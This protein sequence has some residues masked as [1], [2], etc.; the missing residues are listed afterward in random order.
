[1]GPRLKL[2]PYVHAFI[3]RHGRPRFYFRRRGFQQV[4]LHGLPWSAEFMAAY[5]A[6]LS[7]APQMPIGAKRAGP[8][9]VNEAIARYL[10]ST[11]FT[12]VLAP[13]TQALRRTYLERFRNDHGEK[14]LA[15]MEARH[16]AQLLGTLRPH[17]QRNMLKALRGLMAF[18][19]TEG[20]IPVDP[21]ASYKPTR[22][23]DTGGFAPWTDG[24]I[25]KFEATHPVGSRARLALALL[26]F[27]G[28]RR[29]DVVRIGRQHIRDGV[30][31]LKQNKTGAQIDIPVLPEL[32]LVL[33]ATPSDHLTF[34][35][36]ESG[37]P[38][39]AANFGRW[40]RH[41]CNEAGLEKC[42]SAHGLRK[43]AATRLANH[44]ATAHELMAWFGWTTLTE[45][46][47]YTRAVNRKALAQG[48]V[49]KLATGTDSGKP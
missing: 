48:V 20:L 44:G 8:G 42:L 3:D 33:D 34:L 7:D 35:V 38:F 10:Q 2:P 43:A 16:V 37:Q 39:T 36:N 47:R 25:T 18:A 13:A 24:D 28:Q 41:V 31:S 29:G 6:A 9:S 11:A 14:R 1:M 46:E 23:K 26:L 5:D 27:T 32:R 22:I 17:P 40:F 19:V 45:A 21:T 4:A 15:T 12:G 30:L 49:K